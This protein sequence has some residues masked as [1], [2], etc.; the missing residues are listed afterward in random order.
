MVPIAT[1]A[2]S[3]CYYEN[4]EY[5]SKK[6]ASFISITQLKKIIKYAEKHETPINFLLGKK[7]LPK[8][9]TQLINTID[10]VKITPISLMQSYN[11]AIIVVNPNE[12]NHLPKLTK[13][14][15]SNI[16]LRLEKS[17]LNT[18]ATIVTPLLATCKRINLILLELESYSDKDFK[19]Y[20]KQIAIIHDKVLHSYQSG[21]NVE[22]NFLSDRLLL[23]KMNNCD[24]GQTH[25]TI[26]LNGKFYLCPAFYYA[27]KSD[28]I[29]TFKQGI[30]IPNKQ[31]LELENAPI[32][33]HCDA[34]HC[35]RCFYLNK[36]LTAEI[37]TPSHQQCVTA[38]IERNGSHTLR[39]KLKDTI[40][41]IEDFNEISEIDYLDPMQHSIKQN[42]RLLLPKQEMNNTVQTRTSADSWHN[43]IEPKSFNKISNQELARL[44]LHLQNELVQRLSL[45]PQGSTNHEKQ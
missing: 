28:S 2:T 19:D 40:E 22:L 43:V 27:K 10:H 5:H 33:R 24:A 21:T 4:K 30:S 12:R 45:Q 16:I 23:Q 38:H 13:R 34:F 17:V 35:K 8:E 3:F 14:T 44:I 29:G 18:L 1:D 7:R 39:D 37:N 9:Y 6:A 41:N 31:L 25:F 42:E 36:Q 20:K 26:G 11:N 32:C 15:A